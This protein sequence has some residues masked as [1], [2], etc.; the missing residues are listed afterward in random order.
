[1]EQEK[2]TAMAIDALVCKERDS[3]DQRKKLQVEQAKQR[4]LQL[5]EQ[6]EKAK[7]IKEEAARAVYSRKI[8]EEI[9]RRL[10]TERRIKQ[11]QQAE[12]DLM[13]RLQKTNDMQES[14]RPLTWC[15]TF[16]ATIPMI[17]T[18]TIV[19]RHMQNL[20]KFCSKLADPKVQR[21]QKTVNMFVSLFLCLFV[22]LID[23]CLFAHH[24]R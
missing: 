24:M 4:Q 19:I 7:R 14:V 20:L 1:V 13:A 12:Q 2:A 3:V 6:M 21:F 5:K 23:C 11:L 15:C 10:E 18:L 16:R 17:N 9:A 22:C 8:E